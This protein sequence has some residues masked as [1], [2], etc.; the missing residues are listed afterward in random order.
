MEIFP[1]T[2]MINGLDLQTKQLN[3]S[4]AI[5]HCIFAGTSYEKQRI[6]S[7]KIIQIVQSLSFSQFLCWRGLNLEK[8]TDYAIEKQILATRSLLFYNIS[9]RNFISYFTHESFSFKEHSGWL[10]VFFLSDAINQ[11]LFW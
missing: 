3:K 1:N 11:L 9:P 7:V 8:S 5:S 2:W 10:H 4:H 6:I